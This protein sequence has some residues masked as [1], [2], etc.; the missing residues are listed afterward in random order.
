[1]HIICA[2]A[3]VDPLALLALPLLMAVAAV[4]A[5]A[6]GVFRPRAIVGP[7]RRDSETAPESLAIALCIGAGAYLSYASLTVKQTLDIGSVAND[8]VGRALG[9]AAICAVLAFTG[10]RARLLGIAGRK[11]PRGLIV[12]IVSMF[13][14][15][16]VVMGVSQLWATFYLK[17]QYTSGLLIELAQTHN[18]EYVAL[19]LF[20]ILCAAPIS[21]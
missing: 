2:T 10:Y 9:V 19:R 3:P 8:L 15:L 21:E 17:K 11:V 6:L 13:I 4:L 16:P 12:A 20:S 7:A 1:M 18:P 5:I 14:V